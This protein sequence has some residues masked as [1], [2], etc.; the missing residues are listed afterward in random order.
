MV[1]LETSLEE[2]LRPSPKKSPVAMAETK[3]ILTHRRSRVHLGP[4]ETGPVL[5]PDHWEDSPVPERLEM[6]PV[7]RPDR[8][9]EGLHVHVGENHDV[10]AEQ[11]EDVH[12]VNEHLGSGTGSPKRA[13]A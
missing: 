13:G 10:V 8:R 12:V 11:A 3:H 2:K 1:D 4:S 7:R 9:V 5:I 6:H